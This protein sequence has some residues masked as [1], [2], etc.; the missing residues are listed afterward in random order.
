MATPYDKIFQPTPSTTT[1]PPAP[2]AP[3][4]YA[5][6][7]APRPQVPLP[8]SATAPLRYE[9][10]SLEPPTLRQPP[11]LPTAAQIT[12]PPRPD[13]TIKR[14]PAPPPVSLRQP[15][16]PTPEQIRAPSRPDT[17]IAHPAAPPVPLRQPVIPRIEDL[18]PPHVP[19]SAT[20][21]TG[22]ER[23][24]RTPPA[25]LGPER[26]GPVSFTPA[27]RLAIGELERDIP[28]AVQDWWAGVKRLPPQLQAIDPGQVFSLPYERLVDPRRAEATATEIGGT[29]LNVIGATIGAPFI[30]GVDAA[31]RYLT[32]GRGYEAT[33]TGGRGYERTLIDLG[34]PPKTA[35]VIAP[36]LPYI[37]RPD[38]VIPFVHGGLT[39]LGR[40]GD[41]GVIADVGRG[42]EELNR[43]PNAPPSDLERQGLAERT[44]AEAASREHLAQEWAEG[45]Q[46]QLDLGRAWQERQD[47]AETP[48]A[49][50]VAAEQQARAQA[51][52]HAQ[53]ETRGQQEQAAMDRIR[54]THRQQ[55]E[56][57]GHPPTTIQIPLT[58][59][60]GRLLQDERGSADIAPLID[61]LDRQSQA[62]TVAGDIGRQLRQLVLDRRVRRIELR[63]VLESVGGLRGA[64]GRPPAVWER[65]YHAL[66]SPADVAGFTPD[67]QRLYRVTAAIRDQTQAMKE[68]RP[69]GARLITGDVKYVHRIPVDRGL[70]RR[71][72]ATVRGVDPGALLRGRRAEAR[73]PG[74][75]GLLRRTT[76]SQRGRVYM[77]ATDI[78]TGT[79]RVVAE[80]DG[81][82][83][84]AGG[85]FLG[86]TAR[87]KT[88]GQLQARET[89]PVR[90]RLSRVSHDIKMLE[91][92]QNRTPDRI[93]RA[94]R[95]LTDASSD[96]THLSRRVMPKTTAAV[97]RASQAIRDELATWELQGTPDDRVIGGRIA[98]L[99]SLR[100]EL[101][102]RLDEISARYD[103]LDLSGV[104]FKG[105]DG[106]TYRLGQA[107]TREIIAQTGQRYYTHG[108][109]SV[110]MDHFETADAV[111]ASQF[112]ETL[113]ASPDF[114]GKVAVPVERAAEH[115]TWR[116]PRNV[117]P[118]QNWV[119]E[120][121]V[122]S[123][124][125]AIMRDAYG[126]SGAVADALW[127]L[128]RGAVNAG[129]F[130][131][132]IHSPNIGTFWGLARGTRWGDVTAY[133]RLFKTIVMAANDAAHITPRYVEY[134]RSGA[135]LMRESGTIEEMHTA[136]LNEVRRGLQARPETI[137]GLAG[138]LGITVRDIL[139]SP[140][141]ISQ[142]FTWWLEDMTHLQVIYEREL[143]GMPRAQAIR[144]AEENLPGYFAPATV[145]GSQELGA[146]FR[147]R[148]TI[149][150]PYHA[151]VLNHLGG[152][153]KHLL[154]PG[155]PIEER[156][157]AAEKVAMM[158]IAMGVVLPAA[159]ALAQQLTGSRRAR[160]RRAG[161]L[162]PIDQLIRLAQGEQS[163]LG[164]AESVLTPSPAVGAA[165]GLATS[166]AMTRL[167]QDPVE[168]ARGLGAGLAQQ[169]VPYSLRPTARAAWEEAL[170]IAHG[171]PG[172]PEQSLR[173]AIQ[174]RDPSALVRF[175]IAPMVSVPK[176]TPA[177]RAT[178]DW[179]R[180][181]PAIDRRVEDLMAAGRE[182]AAQK[183]ADRH[184]QLLRQLLTKAMR[185]S[186]QDPDPD[187]VELW[188]QRYGVRV[189]RQPHA[190]RR[191]PWEAPAEQAG[192]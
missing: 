191:Y 168:S 126:S 185:D 47:A 99:E 140:W 105:N 39:R 52:A 18:P 67:E 32:R 123:E 104:A 37:V 163:P 58:E 22:A 151:S 171:Q 178:I 108:L 53:H 64:L 73:I 132:F 137:S 97:E 50:D 118:F 88:F 72:A 149:F 8:P 76:S 173:A 19:E 5:H 156:L 114:L 21:M 136:L 138:Q 95:N 122:A 16:L 145:L 65:N 146:V 59:E 147:S 192:P 60:L 144:E 80:V 69:G 139:A 166:P 35:A 148:L 15:T 155:I 4:P 152:I 172:Q 107:T 100:A 86:T 160:V 116:T 68:T 78:A 24:P 10:P 91:S 120:P 17:T 106:R 44:A 154:G 143:E 153:V 63:N 87:K 182:D 43:N 183:L 74:V 141:W 134:L 83:L 92:V 61:Y 89:A 56:A 2:A 186:G 121:R 180:T 71:L 135:G 165:I 11:A 164:A 13:T 9:P 170:A 66:E 117:S 14:Q 175:A 179:M 167:A 45:Q 102:T 40:I 84:G 130:N 184:N 150:N 174:L 111:A 79:R 162:A 129:F 127:R 115:P 51:A 23:I 3:D 81:R 85:D 187:Q 103:P 188:V 98:R 109:A 77:A 55:A 30:V 28:A 177:E 20:G 90:R 189:E 27:G 34:I 54:E 38:M 1:P 113:K 25:P 159:D 49:P 101:Q 158:V 12:A 46:L 125:E 33:F 7:F 82:I 31:E 42:A 57:A 75:P 176:S 96:L 29:L 41:A 161:P 94:V 142:T 119:M 112:V 181:R 62:R 70:G 26:I 133:P 169:A 157:N 124:F 6:I 93:A 128:S 110:L 36:I 48:P 190:P 131:L